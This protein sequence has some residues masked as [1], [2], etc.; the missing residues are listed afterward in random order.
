LSD[1]FLWQCDGNGEREVVEWAAA[2]YP[3]AD[4]IGVGEE[5]EAPA[6]L[7]VEEPQE[8]LVGHATGRREEGLP[9][10]EQ[11]DEL[12]LARLDHQQ[13]RILARVHDAGLLEVGRAH[14]VVLCSTKQVSKERRTKNEEAEEVA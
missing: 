8:G 13:T 10:G 7:V 3:L 11:V 14:L 6:G 4:V 9:L 2:V 12:L 5:V 1:A